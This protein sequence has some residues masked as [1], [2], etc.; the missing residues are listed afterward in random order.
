MKKYTLGAAS[1]MAIAAISLAGCT[2]SEQASTSSSASAASSAASSA[3]ESASSSAQTPD[4]DHALSLVDGV[5]RASTEGKNMTAGFGTIHNNTDKDI[6]IVA[7]SSDDIK[8]NRFE[9][10]EVVNGVMRQKEGGFI[11]PAHGDLK[12]QPGGNHFMFMELTEPVKAG[13]DVDL[14]VTLSDGSTVDFDNVPVRTFGSGDEDYGDIHN[15]H[16]NGTDENAH[17]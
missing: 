4:A 7:V 1:L 5:V 9:L 11:I 15:D 13:D 10:H 12:L 8:A 17:H 14:K 16:S 2:N 3:A 6:N